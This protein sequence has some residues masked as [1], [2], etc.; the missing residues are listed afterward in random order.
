MRRGLVFDKKINNPFIG[1]LSVC[2]LLATMRL[3]AE[4]LL[5]PTIPPDFV[6]GTKAV[7]SEQGRLP[8]W[9][10]DSI[11]I[12]KD[13]R[14]AVINGQTVRQGD[15]VSSAKVVSISATAVTLR[16]NAE[17]FTVKLLPAQIKSAR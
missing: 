16:N 3:A 15:V 5:D 7:S 12:S 2:L 4:P 13:R 6:A 10:V 17:T 1:G 8:A 11:L 9:K 14:M